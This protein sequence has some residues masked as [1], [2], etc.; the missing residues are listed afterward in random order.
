LCRTA[1]FGLLPSISAACGN[2]RSI[3][4]APRLLGCRRSLS[5]M[6]MPGVAIGAV[7]G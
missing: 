6:L 5:S 7:K 2:F 4:D 1:F 3:M